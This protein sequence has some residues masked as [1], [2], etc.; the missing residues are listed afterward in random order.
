MN[1]HFSIERTWWLLRAD[2]AGGYRSLLM[3]SGT[4]AGAILLI[5]LLSFDGDTDVRAFFVS[6][7]GGILFVWGAIASSHAF[8]ELHDKTRNEAYLLTPASAIEKT[9]ARLLTTTVGLT[10]YLLIFTTAVSVL[11][12]GVHLLLP[13]RSLGLFNPIDSELLPQIGA[14]LFLQSFFFLGAAWFRKRHFIKTALALTLTAIGLILLLL[15]IVSVVFDPVGLGDL[16]T[17][18]DVATGSYEEL[19]RLFVTLRTIFLILL[20]LLPLACWTIAWLRV[21]ET[22]VSDGV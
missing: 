9:L 8:R 21:R 7:F 17:L 5:S 4:L 1:E 11:V 16:D 15:L 3:V 14:Y 18:V 19:T 10:V 20:V 6:A 13:D 2:F 22:Q 12:A